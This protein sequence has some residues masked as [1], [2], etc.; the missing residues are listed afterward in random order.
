MLIKIAALLLGVF[1][2]IGVVS[3]FGVNSVISILSKADAGVILTAVALQ[4]IILFLTAVRLSFISRKYGHVPFRQVFKGS[5]V[6]IFAGLLSPFSRIGGEPFKAIA[7]KDRLGGSKSSAVITIDTIAEVV[8]SLTLIAA[9]LF[10]FANEIPK[11]IMSSFIIFLAVIAVVFFA[12]AKIFFNQTRLRR[13][14]LWA[15]SKLRMDHLK[16][17]DYA[18]M[19]LESFSVLVKDKKIM[20][21]TLAIS[22]MMKFLEFARLWLVFLALGLVLPFNIVVIVWAV[23]LVLLLIPWLPGSLGL[24]EFGGASAFIMFGVEKTTAAS[25]I[26]MDRLISFW[27]VLFI[28]IVVI[29]FSE[30]KV[31]NVLK[32]EHNRIE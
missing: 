29:W 23:I 10:L 21:G 2:T 13:L 19:F 32:N 22:F 7:L 20:A 31:R 28:G 14:F 24:V 26:I 1:V 11:A 25:G 12:V 27:L 30:F 16:K 8:S 6:G 17:K 15:I 4:V 3:F 9:V 5:T 18:G